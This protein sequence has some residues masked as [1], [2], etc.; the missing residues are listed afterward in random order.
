MTMSHDIDIA[1]P[2]HDIDGWERYFKMSLKGGQLT[3]KSENVL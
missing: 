2:A 1:F 3:C